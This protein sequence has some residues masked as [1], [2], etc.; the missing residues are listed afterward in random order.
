MTESENKPKTFQEKID[1]VIFKW[2]YVEYPN[3]FNVRKPKPLATG[4]S[5]ILEQQLPENITQA[6]FKLG[7]SWYCQ[8]KEYFKA[9][10]NQEHRYDLNGEIAS[11][12]TEEDKISARE[13]L[14]KLKEKLAAK[15]LAKPNVVEQSEPV[16]VAEPTESVTETIEPEPVKKTLSLKSK[17]TSTVPAEEVKPMTSN[18]SQATAKG[19][20]VTLVIEPAS[21]PEID[22]TGMK[23]APISIFIAN[24]EITARTE[25]NAKS[26]RK[27]LSSI[28][29]YGVDG[30]NV[31]VQG[32]MKQ[33]GV[34][35][36]A[37]IVVQ[38]K[39]AATPTD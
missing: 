11:D 27:A 9:I 34:I 12:I 6:E 19:L 17:K 20:K 14:E 13:R 36:D 3:I 18:A 5:K 7:I 31:I 28:E 26:Y 25:I 4:L 30:C 24:G 33:Y 32:S 2:L 10:I 35:D 21:L 8:R 29:E 16:L 39:K 37:G 38:P 22:T 1:Q 23:K 15:N